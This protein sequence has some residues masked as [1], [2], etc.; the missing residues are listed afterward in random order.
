MNGTKTEAYF[1]IAE[2]KPMD[3]GKLNF[4]KAGELERAIGSTGKVDIYGI[5][6]D[7]DTDAVTP[8]SKPALDEI[9]KLLAAKRD[10]KLKV[11][12]HTDN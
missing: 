4:S 3:T 2:A 12:G 1:V 8:E 11:I 5:L 7:F 9:T 10:L 6:F